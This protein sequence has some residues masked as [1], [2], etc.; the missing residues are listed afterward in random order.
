ML[1]KYPQILVIPI[2]NRPV[3]Y[4]LIKDTAK[5]FN[6][7]NI[8]LPD[9]KLLGNLNSAA[10]VIGLQNWFKETIINNDIDIAIFSL[11][12]LV[13]GGL[14]PSRRT[15]ANFDEVKSYVDSFVSILK[16]SPKNI[17]TYAMSSIMRIS[18]NN[19]NEEEKGYWGTYGVD[20]FRYSYLSHKLLKSYNLELEAELIALSKKI[21]FESVILR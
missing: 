17:K 4:D 8:H 2:D 14:V 3:C 19:Y 16:S 1:E 15:S 7:L 13:Y 18:N 21:P 10:D 11:D 6:G 9:K 5:I 12:T 20:L